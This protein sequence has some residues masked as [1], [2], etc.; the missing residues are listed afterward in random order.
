[1]IELPLNVEAGAPSMDTEYVAWLVD[2]APYSAMA[3]P[4]K[5]ILAAVLAAPDAL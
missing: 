1:L 3:F 4:K 5:L 2:V